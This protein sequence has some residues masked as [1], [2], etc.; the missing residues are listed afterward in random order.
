MAPSNS[1][2]LVVGFRLKFSNHHK[3]A[4]NSVPAKLNGCF[5]FGC[6]CIPFGCFHLF[7]FR[8]F[9]LFP[10]ICPF[11]CRTATQ[12]AS[13]PIGCFR[14]YILAAPTIKLQLLPFGCF[15]TKM[16]PLSL[17]FGQIFLDNS[18]TLKSTS[19]YPFQMIPPLYIWTP[20]FLYFARFC[21]SMLE[22][23]ISLYPD[24][25]VSPFF[26]CFCTSIQR[27]LPLHLDASV[28]LPGLFTTSMIG[29]NKTR[30]H[31]TLS[32]WFWHI[33]R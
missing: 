30:H 12:D 11:C 8:H 21:L 16:L 15:S 6:F 26:R 5:S 23:P 13:F 27:L 25:S 2:S 32:S 33:R 31:N 20:L 7:S 18:L 4:Y 29:I 24:T 10:F 28:R 14:F 1:Y 9:C 3:A 17:L 22:D 19:V